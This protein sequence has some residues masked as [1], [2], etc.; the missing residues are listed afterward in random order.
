MTIGHLRSAPDNRRQGPLTASWYRPSQVEHCRTL[1]TGRRRSPGTA[2][3]PSASSRLLLQKKKT[4]G[5]LHVFRFFV[6]LYYVWHTLLIRSY[7]AISPKFGCEAEVVKIKKGSNILGWNFR[8]I[9]VPVWSNSSYYNNFRS[10]VV[11]KK[12]ITSC[13]DPENCPWGYD[14][15]LSLPGGLTWHVFGSFIM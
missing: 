5:N 15:Y 6:T 4:N 14:G 7:S 13:T 9:T 11:C 12:L 1:D 8:K 10:L 3:C 2:C